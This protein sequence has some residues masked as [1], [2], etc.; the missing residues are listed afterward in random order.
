MFGSVYNTGNI[1]RCCT[2][3]CVSTYCFLYLFISFLNPGTC[4]TP[5][6]R[7]TSPPYEIPSQNITKGKFRKETSKY[8]FI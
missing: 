1:V 5:D 3:I 6:L 8:M 2:K 4:T 7:F